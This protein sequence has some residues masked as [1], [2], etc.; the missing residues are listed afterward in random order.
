MKR[1][2]HKKIIAYSLAVFI[3]FCGT[4]CSFNDVSFYFKSDSEKQEYLYRLPK[5][6]DDA[7]AADKSDNL[8][9]LHNVAFEGKPYNDIRN[10]GNYIL[11]VGQGSYNTSII[12]DDEIKIEYSFDVYDPWHNEITASLSHNDISCDSYEIVGNELWLVSS[13][14]GK[15][16]VYDT[17]LNL[18]ETKD[19]SALDK[20]SGVPDSFDSLYSPSV[21]Y[22]SLDK[23]NALIS[24]VNPQNYKY[25]VASV[26]LSTGKIISSYDGQGFA[27]AAVSDN[28]FVIKT[29][30]YNDIWTYHTSDD[31]DYFFNLANL[32]N[33]TI[34]NDSTLLIRQE[35]SP[36]E[37]SNANH[38]ITGTHLAPDSGVISSF[39]YDIGNFSPDMDS[40]C[41]THSV[42]LPQCNC[43]FYLL[44]TSECNPQLLVWNLDSRSNSK[45][46]TVPVYSSLD[47]IICAMISDGTYVSGYE[48]NFGD[49]ITNIPDPDNY[50]WGVLS[51]VNIAADALEQKYG[52]S[53]YI[54]P[55][56]PSRIDCYDISSNTNAQDISDALEHLNRILACYP[57]N[58]FLQLC[59]G[60][61]RGI[62]IYLAGD[63]DSSTEGTIQEASGFVSNINSYDVMA[64]NINYSSDWDYTVNHEL[65]HLIDQRLDFISQY[66]SDSVFSEDK[67]NSYNPDGFSYLDSYDGYTD[68][69]RYR[70]NQ[71]YFIDSYGITYPTEDRAEIFGTAMD[72]YLNGFTDD[73]NF[74]TDTPLYYKLSYYR[75]C[76]RDGFD[77]T[78]WPDKLPWESIFE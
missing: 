47:D 65:S 8:S 19:V 69:K 7:V 5:F 48:N 77:T 9:L 62:R 41:S 35:T 44:Y 45:D 70:R 56:V 46:I 33:I 43:M 58:F 72:D 50:D 30:S 32:Q 49:T 21:S 28:G 27:S 53:I 60:D 17:S 54:G 15:I 1:S 71:D 67:W 52:I 11:M 12:D 26:D 39:S 13:D 68:S 22:L 37:D 76:I 63:L 6:W 57:D 10:F 61:I 20:L 23:K 18:L 14:T 2:S 42:Y 74:E 78:G 36:K 64:L 40:F 25:Q 51:D 55:E 4:A 34:A 66:K 38:I 73:P 3:A 29:D 31:N 24:G 59:Y 75:K 16:S